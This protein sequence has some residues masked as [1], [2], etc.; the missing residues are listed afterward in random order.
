MARDRLIDRCGR[1]AD[2]PTIV[3]MTSQN[4]NAAAVRAIYDAF[5]RG[6]APAIL[7]RLADDVRWDADWADNLGQRSPIAH[8]LP[9]RGRAE[10][11][12]FFTLLSGYTVREFQV[13]DLLASDRRVSAVVVIDAGMPGGGRYRDEEMHLWTFDAD[14][15]VTAV[16]HYLDTAKHLAAARGEDT[17]VR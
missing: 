16:R 4:T 14:G 3:G 17:T 11:A 8:F 9:R 10:V 2:S 1:P 12:E 5:G 6:D 13:L 15:R 7:D